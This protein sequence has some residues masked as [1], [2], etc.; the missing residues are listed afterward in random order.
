M[1]FYYRELKAGDVATKAL[2]DD[3]ELLSVSKTGNQTVNNST[4]F[5]NDTHLTL[6]LAASATYHVSAMV[7]VSGPTGADYKQLWSFPTGA[8]GLQ[9]IHGPELPVTSVRSTAIQARSASLGTTMTYG[10]DGTENSAIRQ[11]LFL[12]TSTTA[13]NLRLTWAQNAAV[14]SNTTVY[15]GSYMTAYRVV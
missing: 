8:T 1:S 9:F 14:A 7:I 13:G 3:R 4:T 10:T 11:E 6:A 2:L 15:L 5:V 12:S